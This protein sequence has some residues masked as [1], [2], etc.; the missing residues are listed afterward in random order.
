[1]RPNN[2]HDDV[3]ASFWTSGRMGAIGW[4]LLVRFWPGLQRLDAFFWIVSWEEVEVD[5]GRLQILEKNRGI[6]TR[7]K[8]NMLGVSMVRRKCTYLL[9]PTP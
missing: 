3:D 8:T 1:M 6:E 4:Y 2:E 5:T 9:I 7:W